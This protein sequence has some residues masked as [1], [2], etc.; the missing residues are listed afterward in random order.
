[1]LLVWVV[2]LL[3]WIYEKGVYLNEFAMIVLW[4][5]EGCPINNGNGQFSPCSKGFRS[6]WLV[7]LES[8]LTHL[9]SRL[10]KRRKRCIFH[11]AMSIWMKVEFISGWI[12]FQLWYF[13]DWEWMYLDPLWFD[14]F[15]SLKEGN[16]PGI[17]GTYGFFNCWSWVEALVFLLCAPHHFESLW[18]WW[19]LMGVRTYGN[20]V[21]D[22][23]FT[24]TTHGLTLLDWRRATW[25]RWDFLWCHTL[26]TARTWH[27]QISSSFR[28]W[29]KVSKKRGFKQF[30]D[31]QRP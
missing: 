23:H 27:L 25:N 10:L 15:L 28:T 3:S 2:A 16:F 29:R 9:A 30:K 26:L 24:M 14:Q 13:L 19:L 31:Y 8:P 18:E 11:W 7:S 20:G 22:V 21:V 6:L 1:M 4:F 12:S 5:Y 17:R